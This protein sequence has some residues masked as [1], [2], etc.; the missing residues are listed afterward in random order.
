MVKAAPEV[1]YGVGVHKDRNQRCG[2][3]DE[4]IFERLL[5]GDLSLHNLPSRL[6]WRHR[7]DAE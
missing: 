2:E 6:F 5:E 4:T 7:R 3:I 1:T